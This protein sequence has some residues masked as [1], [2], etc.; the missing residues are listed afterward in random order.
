METEI[1]LDCKK[2]GRPSINEETVDAVRVAF[3][4]SPR[5]SSHVAFDELAIPRSTVHKVLHKRLWLHDYK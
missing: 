2:T 3:Y 4:R 5:K 1:I